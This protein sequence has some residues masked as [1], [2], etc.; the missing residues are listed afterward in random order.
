MGG[1]FTL[2]TRER[3]YVLDVNQSCTV[4]TLSVLIADVGSP[5][6]F[7]LSGIAVGCASNG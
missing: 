1:L 4:V 2:V 6:R 5:D 3:S 7:F